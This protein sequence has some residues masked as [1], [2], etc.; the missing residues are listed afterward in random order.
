MRSNQNTDWTRRLLQQLL[1]P[2]Q[3]LIDDDLPDV[4]GIYAWFKGGIVLYVGKAS[5]W[6]LQD[7]ICKNHLQ[8]IT[9]FSVIRNKIAQALCCSPIGKRRY[10][11]P[12]EEEIS[13]VLQLCELRTLET[14]QGQT[15]EA[16]V[17]VIR[18][19]DPPMNDHPG[20]RPRWRIDEVR[21]ILGL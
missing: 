1:I 15:A 7:R 14:S 10:E 19:L 4:H 11:P 2:I 9:Y 16:E 21:H 17:Q 12:C 8:G 5:R 3:G 18:E 6:T 20:Q 13:R